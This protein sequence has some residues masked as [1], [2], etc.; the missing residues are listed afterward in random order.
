M[1]ASPLEPKS[2]ARPEWCSRLLLCG[3]WNSK[4]S[5]GMIPINVNHVNVHGFVK[6]EANHDQSDPLAA[7]DS[8]DSADSRDSRDSPFS[9]CSMRHLGAL[10]FSSLPVQQW[11]RE[12]VQCQDNEHGR[13][14]D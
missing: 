6:H 8:G 7:I 13:L 11:G 9:R 1:I 5:S 12:R 14:P 2:M 10:L 3:R 4:A